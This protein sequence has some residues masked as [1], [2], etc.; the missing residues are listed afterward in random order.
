[1]AIELLRD[2]ADGLRMAFFMFWDTLWPL[3][4]GF[5]LSGAVQAFVSRSELQRALGGHRLRHLSLAAAF[6]AASSSCSYAASALAK[7][8]FQRGADFT[9]A[10]VFMLASTNLVI[11]LGLVLWILIGWQFAVAE[12]VGGIIMIALFAILARF[13]FR[14]RLVE[15]ARRRL[16]SAGD[17]DHHHHHGPEGEG[18]SRPLLRRIRSAAGWS[19]AAAYTMADLN[20]IRRELVIGYVVAGFIA[21]LVPVEVWNLVFLHGHGLATA[22]ENALVGPLI[23]IL[24][25]VCSVGNVPL[26]AALWQGGISF[27]GV[28]SFI[29][30]DLITLPL[31]LI[32]RRFYGWALTL[33]LLGVFWLVMAVAGLATEGL[34]SLAGLVPAGR[35]ALVVQ[36]Q[37][38][39]N[40]TTILN[41]VFL[42]VFAVQI[43]LYRNRGRL[44]G[45]AGYATDPVCGMQVRVSEAP[46][47]AEHDGHRYHFCSDRCRDRFLSEPGRH[48]SRGGGTESVETVTD[49]V[50]G[51]QVDPGTALRAEVGGRTEH[52]CS[53]HCRE[54]FLRAGVGARRG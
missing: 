21:V 32:Y 30:A 15:A 19:D 16:A 53:D 44:G 26:A 38:S 6:G 35:S 11:E 23:A 52:F 24:S 4:L 40:A 51:M 22:V 12:Y 8:L 47:T 48:A 5:G 31:L 18:D 25:F 46:A 9:A 3:I 50:C 45:G 42:G 43:W 41:V 34:F 33:R 49:P 54:Q 37:I 28:V 13:V 29:F 10:I 27:G 7:S 20:M 14:P 17:D 39:W 2:A 36:P 1:M